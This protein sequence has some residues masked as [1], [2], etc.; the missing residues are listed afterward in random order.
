MIYNSV[1]KNLSQKAKAIL[2]YMVHASIAIAVT[3]AVKYSLL[4]VYYD[5]VH[6]VF[7]GRSVK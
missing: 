1:F 3:L 5:Y 4:E 6:P 7:T 2:K